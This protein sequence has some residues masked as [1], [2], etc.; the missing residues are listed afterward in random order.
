MKSNLG[1]SVG[2]MGAA[3]Y[4]LGLFGGWIPAVMIAGYVLLFESN[5]W[6]R[7]SVI[8]AVAICVFFSI[9]SVI[10]GLIP[11]AINLVDNIFSIFNGYF[12]VDILSK[13]VALADSILLIA[14]TLL[15]LMLGFRALHQGTIGFAMIDRL[16]LK[17]MQKDNQVL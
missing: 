12:S 4:F 8:K 13:F 7:L 3:T 10:I 14:K 6:L 16:I 15:L 9:V 5:E 1:I 17:H 2:L 11:S